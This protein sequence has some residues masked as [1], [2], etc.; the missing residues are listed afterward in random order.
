MHG[1]EF[2][3]A[4]RALRCFCGVKC[5]RMDILKREMAIDELHSLPEPSQEQ[6]DYSS[7]LLAVGAFEVAILDN[8]HWRMRGP[9]GVVGRSY[10]H[11]ELEGLSVFHGLCATRPRGIVDTARFCAVRRRR[12][13]LKGVEPSGRSRAPAS[14]AG[15]CTAGRWQNRRAVL[16]ALIAANILVRRTSVANLLL[17]QRQ[18]TACD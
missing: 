4:G 13:R 12:T 16:V 3:L 1:P 8:R 14:A 5:V 7:G 6:L 2:A 17:G 10:C 9:Y 18:I 15:T 11:R